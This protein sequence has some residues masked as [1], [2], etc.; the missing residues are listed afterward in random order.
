[1]SSWLDDIQKHHGVIED[2]A[3]KDN[4]S[5]NDKKGEKSELQENN[6]NNQQET[7]NSDISEEAE[8]NNEFSSEV[9]NMLSNN[10]VQMELSKESLL[11]IKAHTKLMKLQ[12]HRYTN[13][14]N[15]VKTSI[16]KFLDGITALLEG[17]S[18]SVKEHIKSTDKLKTVYANGMNL[19]L[20][21]KKKK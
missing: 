19:R 7:G 17:F 8:G 5:N 2:N 12:G 9:E 15:E 4:T 16:T 14:L 1:M 20:P 10:L 11:F 6:T 13:E 21:C 3:E 18:L